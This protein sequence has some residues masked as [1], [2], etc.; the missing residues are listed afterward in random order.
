MPPD[1][2]WHKNPSL[3][4]PSDPGHTISGHAGA[5]QA[6]QTAAAWLLRSADLLVSGELDVNAAHNKV[7]HGLAVRPRDDL[8]G[9]FSLVGPS[10]DDTLPL[11]ATTGSSAMDI[12]TRTTMQFLSRPPQGGARTANLELTTL[13]LVPE[14]LLAEAWMIS[15]VFGAMFHHAALAHLTRHPTS[16]DD[17]KAGPLRKRP[18]VGDAPRLPLGPRPDQ[19]LEERVLGLRTP[20]TTRTDG[21]AGRDTALVFEN[22]VVVTLQVDVSN[23]RTVTIVDD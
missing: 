9:L 4:T 16:D 5:V 18:T 1:L 21:T 20:F 19:M 22:G 7:K 2:R 17:P 23:A 3:A 10:D 8:R 6:V 15:S 12:F 14:R 11:S 13:E